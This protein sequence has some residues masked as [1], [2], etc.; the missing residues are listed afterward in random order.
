MDQYCDFLQKKS[1][2]KNCVQGVRPLQNEC[3]SRYAGF[4][5]ATGQ[6]KC[7]GENL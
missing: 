1:F 4:L 7:F 6:K 5:G 3:P 2:L